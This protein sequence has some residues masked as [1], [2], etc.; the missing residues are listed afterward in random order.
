M[1]RFSTYLLLA[2]VLGTT[3][4]AQPAEV[5]VMGTRHDGN[6]F[7]NHKVLLAELE[8]LQPDLVLRETHEPFRRIPGLLVADRLGIWSPSIE[9]RALQR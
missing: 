8:Q 7:L 3:V 2:L 1:I 6:A 9:Q 5:L 4:V